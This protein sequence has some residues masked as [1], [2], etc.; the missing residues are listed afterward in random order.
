MKTNHNVPNL[1]FDEIFPTHVRDIINVIPPYQDDNLNQE[2]NHMDPESDNRFFRCSDLQVSH[3]ELLNAISNL[4]PKNS[5]DYNGISMKFIKQHFDLIIE[6]F[7][8]IV[9]LSFSTGFVPKQLK[10]AKVIPVFKSGDPRLPNNYRPISLLS[11]FSK[12]LEKVMANRLTNYLEQYNLLSPSQ[13]GF[14]KNHSTVES[15]SVRSLK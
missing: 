2:T 5:N 12:I 6:P 3:E 14:R 4:E 13:F 15:K 8:Y 11:N 10:I 7:K 1:I 9:D